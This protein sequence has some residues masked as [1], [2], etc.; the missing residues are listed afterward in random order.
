M[1]YM[2]HITL[3]KQ[4]DNISIPASSLSDHYTTDEVHGSR[5]GIGTQQPGSYKLNMSGV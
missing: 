5:S 3:M 1:W 2:P 4:W